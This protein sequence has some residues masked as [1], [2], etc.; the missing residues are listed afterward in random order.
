MNHCF[1]INILLTPKYYLIY[2]FRYNF[3]SHRNLSPNIPV[4][5]A[6]LA[7]HLPAI[8]TTVRDITI[9]RG[10]FHTFLSV[11][12]QTQSHLPQYLYNTD[13]QKIL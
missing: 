4:N 5:A 2:L 9:F 3:Q 11:A 13:F 8:Y 12:K 1:I 10:A 7:M 6:L